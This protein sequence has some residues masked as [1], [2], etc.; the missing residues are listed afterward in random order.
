MLGFYQPFFYLQTRNP[1]VLP[2]GVDGDVLENK[3]ADSIGTLLYGYFRFYA[4]DFN[5]YQHL[6]SIKEGRHPVYKID[7]IQWNSYFWNKSYNSLTVEDPVEPGRVYHPK[8]VDGFYQDQIC[9]EMR[10]A[11]YILSSGLPLEC[12]FSGHTEVPSLWEFSMNKTPND[13]ASS[14]R[15]ES[16]YR[17]MDSKIGIDSATHPSV[18]NSSTTRPY[19]NNEEIIK[20]CDTRCVR[21]SPRLGT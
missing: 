9:R 7:R 5:F 4:Y 15:F 10:K 17:E 12:I 21:F 20:N 6:V 8:G 18:L 2:I 1:P 19:V 16:G 13:M 14:C 3:N 11:V